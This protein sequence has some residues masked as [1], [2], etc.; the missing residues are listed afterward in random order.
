M[1]TESSSS[2]NGCE[3][4]VTD[5]LH[6]LTFKIIFPPDGTVEHQ[7]GDKDN[8]KWQACT[9]VC[10]VCSVSGLQIMLGTVVLGQACALISKA[11]GTRSHTKDRQAKKRSQSTHWCVSGGRGMTMS[12][13]SIT[14]RYMSAVLACKPHLHASYVC[15]QVP[16]SCCTQ[17]APA[18]QGNLHYRI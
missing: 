2:I 3:S 10:Q 4:S 16:F 18:L 9:Q 8:S 13:Q 1:S 15:M 7:F 11:K 5:L 6:L 17:A 14:P 12:A